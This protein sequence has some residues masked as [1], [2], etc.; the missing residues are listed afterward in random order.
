M[1]LVLASLESLSFPQIAPRIS[2]RCRTNVTSVAPSS[3][4]SLNNA[5]STIYQHLTP[6]VRFADDPPCCRSMLQGTPE[7]QT[8][9]LLWSDT[10]SLP[11]TLSPPPDLIL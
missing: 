11:A 4:E 9:D 6:M 10:T 3:M 7:E 5:N 2:F 1:N 8:H